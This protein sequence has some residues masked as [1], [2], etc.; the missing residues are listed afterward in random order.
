MTGP[1]NPKVAV[2][3]GGQLWLV[4]ALDDGK[5]RSVHKPYVGISI[6]VAQFA[7]TAVVL[8]LQLLHVEC[9]NDDVVQEGDEHARMH[10]NV[11]PVVDLRQ[12][13]GWDD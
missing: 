10:P 1:E 12:D 2:V 8:G 9:A 5:D 4:E 3:K 11:H 13:W 7:D 6:P